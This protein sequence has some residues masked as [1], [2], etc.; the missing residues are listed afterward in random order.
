MNRIKV[1]LKQ[2]GMKQTLLSEKLGKSIN[3]INDYCNNRRQPSLEVLFRI[4]EILSVNVKDLI[5]ENQEQQ[6]LN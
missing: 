2:K 6:S 4:A 5:S 3:V 1:I